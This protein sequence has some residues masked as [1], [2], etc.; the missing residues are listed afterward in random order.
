M[1]HI[2]AT[3]IHIRGLRQLPAFMNHSKHSLRQ[4]LKSEGCVYANMSLRLPLVGYTL[5]VWET[6]ED[7]ILYKNSGPHRTA[8]QHIG[9][10]SY[11]YRTLSWQGDRIPSMKEA[12]KLLRDVPFKIIK[13]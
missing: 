8:M 12:R 10:L 11:R 2:V 3:E 1:K 13:S 9:A 6:E 7:M 4:A 5:T